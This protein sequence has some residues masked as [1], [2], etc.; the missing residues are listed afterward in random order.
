MYRQDVPKIAA[1]ARASPSGTGSVLTFALLSIRQ[2]FASLPRAVED[3]KRWGIDSRY[4]WG[5][6]RLGFDYVC[7]HEH[8]LWDT[9]R[10]ADTFDAI[11][12]LA[13]TV[14]GLGIVKGAFVAQMFG[15][16]VACFDS[17][18]LEALEMPARSFREVKALSPAN[19]RRKIAQYVEI[20]RDTG[21]A[22]HWWDSWC[23]G[24]APSLGLSP[25]GV[26]RQHV[27]LTAALSPAI[28]AAR[29]AA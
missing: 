24:I 7:D 23:T 3:V 27:T 6:K 14:P 20:T 5:W 17:R 9:L 21:G 12:Y 25:D 18:N 4:L 29:S 22:A 8:E 10:T 15:H 16:E 19:R 1:F 13:G 28:D 26:S 11:D 2:P